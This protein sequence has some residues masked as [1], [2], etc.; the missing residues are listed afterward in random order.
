MFCILLF[1]FVSYVFLLLYLCIL[2]L[3]YVLFCIFCFH[4]ANWHSSSTL[5]EVF[6][7]FSV[8]CKANARYNLQRE[9]TAR[10]LP[11]LILLFYVLF[12]CRCVLYYCQRVSTQL[13]LQNIYKICK[14]IHIYNIFYV[15]AHNHYIFLCELLCAYSTLLWL[16]IF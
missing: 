2:T 14:Y 3:M 10:T 1:N 12:A 6:P 16:C 4:H 15:R 7:C 13:Q 8:S 5:T 11:K 9:G